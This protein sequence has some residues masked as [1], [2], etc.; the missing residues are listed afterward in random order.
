M[1]TWTLEDVD[2]LK[3]HYPQRGQK[4]CA[5][6]LGRTLGSIRQK[7]SDLKLRQDKEGIFFKDWQSRAAQSKVGKKRPDHAVLMRRLTKEGRLPAMRPLTME[8]RKQL[9]A[10]LK[11]WHRTHEHPQGMLGKRHTPEV[12]QALS[13][14]SKAMWKDPNS[15][16]NSQEYRQQVSDRMS[17]RQNQGNLRSGYSR[18]RMGTYEIN[19]RQMFFRSLWEV[20]YALYLDFLVKQKQ[21]KSWEYEVDTFWFEAIKRGVR[22]YKPD[23]KILNR[24]DSI[25]YHEVKGWMDTKSKTKLARMEK[26]HP[27]VKLILVDESS[28]KDIKKKLGKAIG[29]YE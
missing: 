10:K 14:R 21:I 23:F 12:R 8:E 16:L 17:K 7:A 1:K 25:E 4:W 24:D 26:Y 13:A 27:S 9:S 28:Y 20:N 2:F 18:G 3:E 15:Y 6:Q 22:S 19:G 5:D 11:E 29:F